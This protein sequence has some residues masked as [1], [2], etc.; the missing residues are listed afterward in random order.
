MMH[1]WITR[2]SMHLL[3]SLPMLVQIIYIIEKLV[4]TALYVSW[5][6]SSSLVCKLSIGS[7]V[8]QLSAVSETSS[9]DQSVLFLALKNAHT[10]I[11]SDINTAI[12]WKV[13]IFH[14]KSLLSYNAQ[15]PFPYRDVFHILQEVSMILPETIGP[16]NHPKNQNQTTGNCMVFHL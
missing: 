4:N 15:A 12:V 3:S 11:H 7:P 2:V 16:A 10:K 14:R 8:S 1:V 6:L 5:I 13:K 9:V